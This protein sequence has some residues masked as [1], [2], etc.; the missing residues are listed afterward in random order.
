MTEPS[1]A[2][3]W[4]AGSTGRS[5]LRALLALAAALLAQGASAAGGVWKCPGADGVPVYQDRPCAGQPLRDF[6]ADPP[7]LSV[8]PLVVLPSERARAP[9]P[10]RAPRPE[11]R[12]AARTETR[13]KREAT[14]MPGE[15]GER[16]HL[17]EGMSE[18][19][20]LARVGSPDLASGKGSRRVRWTFLPAPGD[21]QTMTM[22]RFEDG[23]VAGVERVT[24]R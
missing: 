21:P 20:V 8:V 23:R 6:T 18:G 14:R 12:P 19:E 4:A 17:R 15:A 24:V 9:P 1:P 7:A 3:P 13:A 22:V 5:R 2:A 11:A 10:R 16:R